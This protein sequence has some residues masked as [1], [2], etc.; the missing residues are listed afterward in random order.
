MTV[1]VHQHWLYTPHS[2][3]C[4]ILSIHCR[5]L[6]CKVLHPLLISRANIHKFL[7]CTGSYLFIVWGW[8]V[9]SCIDFMVKL[10]A[11][12]TVELRIRC[13]VRAYVLTTTSSTLLDKHYDVIRFSHHCTSGIAKLE[14]MTPSEFTDQD[15][16]D[17]PSEYH[18]NLKTRHHHPI[19]YLI[20]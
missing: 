19:T 12:S 5:G 15:P 8:L 14:H 3:M 18:N 9:K 7:V 4:W 11:N 2:Q 17:C 1:V 16:Q 20:T 13:Y 10:I 6:T